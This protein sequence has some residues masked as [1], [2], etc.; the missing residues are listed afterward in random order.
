LVLEEK[1]GKK[2]VF[3]INKPRLEALVGK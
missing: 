3:K 1:Q 2:L